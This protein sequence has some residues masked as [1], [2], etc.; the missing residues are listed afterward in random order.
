[1]P[2]N[3]PL[4]RSCI[5]SQEVNS[6][7]DSGHVMSGVGWEAYMSFSFVTQQPVAIYRNSGAGCLATG[8]AAED[9]DVSSSVED[10]ADSQ[11]NDPA[12]PNTVQQPPT[13]APASQPNGET[14]SSSNLEEDYC[15]A[16][17]KPDVGIDGKSRSPQYASQLHPVGT[18]NSQSVP[19]GHASQER[20]PVQQPKPTKLCFTDIASPKDLPST[21]VTKGEAYGCIQCFVDI[22]PY[23][24]RH[25]C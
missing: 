23:I 22:D 8:K 9:E 3:S 11:S 20:Q 24:D 10:N 25:E 12:S 18:D 6:T 16:P 17:S 19:L 15:E 1:M 2:G 5:N 7:G 4:Q 21:I 14:T 13:H